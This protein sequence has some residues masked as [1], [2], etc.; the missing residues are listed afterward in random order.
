MRIASKL[1]ADYIAAEV[2][3]PT[4][5]LALI[6]A[7]RTAGGV[8]AYAGATDAAS[9]LK[10]LLWQKSLDFY[11]EGQRQGDWRRQP[12]A[13]T[14]IPV[15]GQAYFKPG[16]PAIGNKTCYPLPITE[17]DNNPNLKGK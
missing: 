5:Q 17:R 8:G 6:A 2:A 12:A 16:F 14:G 3:G 1:E 4:A 13:M 9:V 10:E 11:L 7:R 15:P